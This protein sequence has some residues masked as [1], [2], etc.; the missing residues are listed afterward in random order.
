MGGLK[1]WGI[2]IEG[3]E[4]EG[5]LLDRRN[6]RRATMLSGHGPAAQGKQGMRG[7]GLAQPPAKCGTAGLV[8]GGQQ[9]LQAANQLGRSRPAQRAQQARHDVRH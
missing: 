5:C 6:S 4:C 2:N 3:R 8:L 1:C 9:S 7:A